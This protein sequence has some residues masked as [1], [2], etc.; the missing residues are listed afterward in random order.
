[1]LST[2]VLMSTCAR[3]TRSLAV[4]ARSVP[5]AARLGANQVPATLQ[6][7]GLP[8]RVDCSACAWS[9]EHA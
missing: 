1:M 8:R 5:R 6:E 7:A 9:P 3:C 4:H 2:A